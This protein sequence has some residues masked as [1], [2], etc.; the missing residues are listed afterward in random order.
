MNIPQSDSDIETSSG[1]SVVP[2][3]ARDAGVDV[4]FA[5]PGTT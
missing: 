2:T 5:N 4:C 3:T 1:A